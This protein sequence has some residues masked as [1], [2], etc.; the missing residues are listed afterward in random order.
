MVLPAYDPFEHDSRCTEG[1][2]T[3]GHTTGF[4][5]R[6]H[7]GRATCRWLPAACKHHCAATS[8]HEKA[9][10]EPCEM[11][12][13]QHT[14]RVCCE[15]CETHTICADPPPTLAQCAV[16]L[17]LLCPAEERRGGVQRRVRAYDHQRAAR[18]A[19]TPALC[20][21]GTTRLVPSG[22][23]VCRLP[24]TE[25]ATETAPPRPVSSLSRVSQSSVRG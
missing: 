3:D 19:H 7:R 22:E 1:R 25:W 20:I 5:I 21:L 6:V 16:L 4:Q 8:V 18:R 11:K 23:C 14:R 9:V 10:P 24:A 12:D 17:P 2:H 13:T 15:K